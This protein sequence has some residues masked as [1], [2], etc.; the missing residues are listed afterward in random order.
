V[1]RWRYWFAGLLFES[2][3]QIPEWDAFDTREADRDPDVRIVLDEETAADA[4]GDDAPVVTPDE[5]R[6]V[7]RG[8]ARFQILGGRRIS[9]APAAGADVREVRLF[10]LGSALAALCMQREV[11]L[12]HASVVRLG[13]RTIALCGPAGSGKSTTAAALIERGG[14]FVCDD[15][16][17]FDAVDGRAVVFPSTPRLKL[18]P[19]ALAALPWPSGGFER[20]HSRATK[21]HVSQ[22]HGDPRSPV[23]L[24]AIYLLEWADG[25][26][27]VTTLTG[28]SS[29]RAVV[30]SGT[31]RPDLLG[32]MGQLTGH[33]QRCA[34]LAACLS[35]HRLARP[36]QWTALDAAVTALETIA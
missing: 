34:A 8:V 5:Y 27:G 21:F 25:A 17:R 22:V 1:T 35:V 36:R 19:E 7:V 12:L 14:A 28:V 32:P 9:V 33:W 30:A 4:A 23:P 10:L 15:L 31:Y 29:L 11:L 16:G 13:S 20:V 18:H 2:A 24:D 26:V 3:V 6:F